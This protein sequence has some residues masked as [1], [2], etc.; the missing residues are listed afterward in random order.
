LVSLRGARHKNPALRFSLRSGLSDDAKRQIATLAP[1]LTP[2]VAV[3][4]ARNDNG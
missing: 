4:L 1:K 3:G 2:N